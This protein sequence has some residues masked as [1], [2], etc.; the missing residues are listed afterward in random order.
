MDSHSV[1]TIG[2]I[3]V[4][5]VSVTKS[6]R[7]LVE[8]LALSR[9][10]GASIVALV[11]AVWPQ[12]PPTTAKSSI[13][14]QIA[15]LRHSFGR[16][17]IVKSGDR[18]QLVATTDI[19]AIDRAAAT[20]GQFRLAPHDVRAVADVLDGWN[21]EPYA[22]LPDHPRAQAERARL[23]HVQNRLVET[24]ALSRL[25]DP[26]GDH[27]AAII[28][29]TVRT[30]TNPLHEQAWELLVT[31]LHL[32]GRR[33]EAL[34]TFTRFVDVLDQQI[35]AA[36]SRRF[37]RLRGVVDADQ[38]IDPMAVLSPAGV[39]APLPLRATA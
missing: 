25:I 29:L 33:T 31:A 3:T 32:S 19:D 24:L 39:V 14:N 9:K 38:S 2:A 6:Q 37:Q 35:G 21:G 10:Y 27:E 11:D 15:R 34:G 23:H 7:P 22:D 4:D 8:A 30:S 20:C 5:G 18:Y 12:Q 36:P 28:D 13:Q 17:L 1:R 16:E 26:A